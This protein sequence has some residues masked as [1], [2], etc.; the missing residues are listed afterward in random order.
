MATVATHITMAVTWPG[1]IGIQPGSGTVHIW[2]L[3]TQ[4]YTGNTITGTGRPCG[5]IIPD[6][7]A[8]PIA[9]GLKIGNTIADS[10]WDSP[11]MPVA[12]ITGMQSGFEAGNTVSINKSATVVGATM[13]NPLTDIWPMSYTGLMTADH[14][15]DTK[16]GITATPKTGPGYQLPP[17]NLFMTGRADKLYLAT[18]SIL[19]LS[20]TRDTCDTVTGTATM[21]K[22]DNHVVGCHVLNGG[23]CLPADTQ[24]VDDNR[25]IFVIGIATYK[26]TNLPAGATCADARASLP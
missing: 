25:T 15:G 3:A 13:A 2:T 18:R 7:T 1:T 11:N 12:M 14:D 10:A 24:F 22:F 21:E 23:E 4:N 8:T 9:G 26:A 20:G 5:S 16:V 6:L 19:S 17:L